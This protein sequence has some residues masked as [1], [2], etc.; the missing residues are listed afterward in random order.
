MELRTQPQ[1][2]DMLKKSRVDGA[3]MF[4]RVAEATLNKM[5][6]PTDL[7]Q[8][9]F[10][11]HTSYIYVAFNR[12]NE[13]SSYVAEVLGTGLWRLQSSS[14]YMQIFEKHY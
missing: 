7:L 6:L 10:L 1:I 14:A 11:N 3:I 8:A 5:V 4:E 12:T 13:K 2:V 9:V